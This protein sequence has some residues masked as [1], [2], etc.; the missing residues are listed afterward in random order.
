MPNPYLKRVEPGDMSAAMR[1]FWQGSMDLRGDATFLEVSA[2][3]ED[4]FRWYTESFYDGVFN[5]GLVSRKFKELARLRLSNIHGCRFCN[6]GNRQDALNAGITQEQIDHLHAYETGPFS[7]MEKA[8]LRLADQMS[9]SCP[10]G[11]LSKALYEDLADHF[12]DAEIYELGL[13]MGI[14][15]GVAKFLFAFDLVERDPVCPIEQE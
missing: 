5:K 9:L 13:V 14:L 6:Q 1:E 15:T 12:N 3:H 7:D 2:N 8:V 4:L 11:Q 10:K